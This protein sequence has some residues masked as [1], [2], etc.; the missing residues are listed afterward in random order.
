VSVL[1]LSDGTH[2]IAYV[3]DR[4]I[5]TVDLPENMVAASRSGPIE[6]SLLIHGEP[7]DLLDAHWLFATHATPVQSA[8]RPFCRLPSS[9]PWAQSILAPLVE[10][11]GYMVVDETFDGDADVAI[12][13]DDTRA[14]GL[15]ATTLI[16]LSADPESA[17]SQ[18]DRLYRYDRAGLLARLATLRAGRAA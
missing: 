1:R 3:F 12:A 10:A 14:S 9:D 8:A 2:E 15:L 4:I 18:G 5:D 17:S 16:Q 13:T 7:A 6:G 11:A